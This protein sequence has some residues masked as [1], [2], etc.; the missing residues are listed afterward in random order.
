MRLEIEVQHLAQRL[1]DS[2]AKS[3]EDLTPSI[4]FI[5]LQHAIHIFTMFLLQISKR[6]ESMKIQ[7]VR[8]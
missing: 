5:H 4:S 2:I 3:L 6:E 1:R 7:R 8:G